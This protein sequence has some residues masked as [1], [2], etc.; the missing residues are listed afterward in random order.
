MGAVSTA[1]GVVGG[2]IVLGVV[3]RGPVVNPDGTVNVPATA[4]E[5]AHAGFDAAGDTVAQGT[6]GVVDG[7]MDSDL[8]KA[9]LV[10]AGGYATGRVA[11]AV[12]GKARNSGTEDEEPSG[13]WACDSLD[14]AEGTPCEVSEDDEP[15]AVGAEDDM[16]LDIPEIGAPPVIVFD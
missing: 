1:A 4:R 14:D 15:V 3:M 13:E 5:G 10:I 8:A 11:V 12:A 16:S 6:S 9:G 2:L 7:V